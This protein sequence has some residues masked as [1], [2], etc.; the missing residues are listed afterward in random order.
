M[1]KVDGKKC[2]PE[3]VGKII[4]DKRLFGYSRRKHEKA[5]AKDK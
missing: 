3:G 4:K 2:F 5:K 1:E